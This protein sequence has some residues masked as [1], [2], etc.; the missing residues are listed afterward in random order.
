MSASILCTWEK[1]VT[2]LNLSE[3]CSKGLASLFP[4]AR[5]AELIEEE[6]ESESEDDEV[7]H[8]NM[9]SHGTLIEGIF[10][11]EDDEDT[12][13]SCEESNSSSSS[14]DEDSSSNSE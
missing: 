13:S 3:Q 11:D 2:P 9:Q 8:A 4:A 12:T 10:D 7:N 6:L 5:K 1:S 14:S